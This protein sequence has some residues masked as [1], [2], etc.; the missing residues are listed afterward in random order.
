MSGIDFYAV[1]MRI[2]REAVTY[3]DQYNILA[4]DGHADD[5]FSVIATGGDLTPIAMALG[6]AEENLITLITRTSVGQHKLLAARSI[7]LA[8]KSLNTLDSAELASSD[9]M[10]KETAAAAK[11]HKDMLGIGL[12]A[13]GD[14]AGVGKP[15]QASTQQVIVHSTV[16]IGNNNAP[17]P[18]PDELQKVLEHA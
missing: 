9:F 16:S 18:L 10:M 13:S 15:D 3:E 8:M 12:K 4:A 14:L 1:G 7:K 2:R 5:I 6:I 17:P 11:H